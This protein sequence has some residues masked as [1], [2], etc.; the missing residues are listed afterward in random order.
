MS[1]PIWHVSSRSSEVCCELLY[2]VYLYFYLYLYDATRRF[3]NCKYSYSS[4]YRVF[5]LKQLFSE[6]SCS[7][8]GLSEE[9]SFQLRSELSSVEI[10]YLLQCFDTVGWALRRA[11][12]LYKLTDG[13]LVWLSAWSEVQIVCI[14]S[15]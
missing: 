1:D 11:L 15:C 8:V 5:T 13:V 7:V 10:Y 2:S 6:E 3:V 4:S 14:W 9:M 12:G